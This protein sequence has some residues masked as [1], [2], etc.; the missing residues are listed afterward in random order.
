M[1]TSTLTGRETAEIQGTLKVIATPVG[2]TEGFVIVNQVENKIMDEAKAFVLSA[3]YDPSFVPD[4]INY[5]MVGN[6]GTATPAG[7]DPKPVGGDRTGLFGP[8]VAGYTNT[9]SAP[10]LSDGG[11]VATF[12]FS[13]P[14]TDLN[15]EYINEVGMF[16][17]SDALFNMKTF[18]SILKTS[19]FSLT[20]IWTIRHK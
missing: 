3:I 5:F 14:D 10:A 6:E 8:I 16:R 11:K 20:F 1:N 17:D 18:S 7:A 13:I 15:G 12:S 19:G 2:A 4:P 9:V